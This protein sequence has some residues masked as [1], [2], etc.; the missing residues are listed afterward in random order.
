MLEIGQWGAVAQLLA[1]DHPAVRLST[2]C[3]VLAKK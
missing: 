2:A 3:A 1:D